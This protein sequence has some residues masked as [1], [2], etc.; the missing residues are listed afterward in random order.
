MTEEH[1]GDDAT[2]VYPP[3][4]TSALCG[5]GD[6]AGCPRAPILAGFKHWREVRRAVQEDPIWCPTIWTATR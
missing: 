3:C 2:R 6:C 5:R 4:C 1:N